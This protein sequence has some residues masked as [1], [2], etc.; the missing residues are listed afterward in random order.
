MIPE[1]SA[2]FINS[3]VAMLNLEV[4]IVIHSS[5]TDAGKHD[6]LKA[7]YQEYVKFLRDDLVQHLF[8]HGERV[9]E[10]KR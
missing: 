9:Y 8:V 1:Q 7:L 4:Q 2:A 10:R 5:N 3:Q 6:A